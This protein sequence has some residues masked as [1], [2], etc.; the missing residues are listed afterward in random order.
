MKKI[1]TEMCAAVD[2]C[3][4]YS[5]GN[6]RVEKTTNGVTVWLHGNLICKKVNGVKSYYT[7]GW[8]SATTCSRLN[9]LGACVSRR[10]GYIH[11]QDG[12]PV[13][14]YYKPY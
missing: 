3:Y 10:G 11:Y 5:K 2:G 4:N 1:E 14:T 9:A 13:Q 8:D 12:T 7:A 6:T